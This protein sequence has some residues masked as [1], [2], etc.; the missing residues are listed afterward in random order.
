MGSVASKAPSRPHT[1]G[2]HCM[3][4]DLCL[5]WTDTK[6]ISN[7]VR[8]AIL[9]QKLRCG[10]AIFWFIVSVQIKLFFHVLQ[11]GELM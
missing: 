3:F 2:V 6:K 7:T 5:K 10:V 8:A 4:L 1:L 9:Y 11:E